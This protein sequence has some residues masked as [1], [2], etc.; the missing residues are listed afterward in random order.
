MTAP[1]SHEAPMTH[2]ESVGLEAGTHTQG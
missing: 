2:K 1:V